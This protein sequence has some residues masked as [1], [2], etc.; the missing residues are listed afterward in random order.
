MGRQK[1]LLARHNELLEWAHLHYD[2]VV[3]EPE[4]ES[5]KKA[6]HAFERYN[7]KK[8][9]EEIEWYHLNKRDSKPS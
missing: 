5:W 7:D 4:S 6:L 8:I 3:G 2:G 1:E 9:D